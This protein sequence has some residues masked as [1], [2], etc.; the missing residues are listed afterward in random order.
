MAIGAA[1]GGASTALLGTG[2][3]GMMGGGVIGGVAAQGSSDVIDQRVSPW[4]SYVFAAGTGVLFNFG[5]LGAGA[6]D[7][8]VVPSIGELR[9]RRASLW[10]VRTGIFRRM[11]F[12][13]ITYP[14]TRAEMFG[15]LLNAAD[16]AMAT[17][18]GVIVAG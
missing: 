4:Q 10:E 17:G 7:V 1:T 11:V 13:A 5:L 6:Y 14:P 2:T 18:N 9:L 3:L 12:S 16:E 15:V 8:D